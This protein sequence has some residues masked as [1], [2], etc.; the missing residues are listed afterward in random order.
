[1]GYIIADDGCVASPCG[2]PC[3]GCTL[4]SCSRGCRYILDL[5]VDPVFAGL[6]VG[7]MLISGLVAACSAAKCKKMTLDVRL[8][9]P[10]LQLYKRIGFAETG[11]SWGMTDR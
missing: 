6:G 2:L 11:R 10:A 9:N 5:A 4:L 7:T 1:M 8:H 3:L